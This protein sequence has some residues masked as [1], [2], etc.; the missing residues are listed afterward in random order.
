MNAA[1][2]SVGTTAAGPGQL[3]HLSV[4]LRNS[5][6]QISGLQFDVTY[7]QSA[8]T[9][10][11]A[12]GSA[13]IAAG[14]QVT[15]GEL[16]AGKRILIVGFNQTAI[17]DGSV[18]DFTISVGAS[19]SGSYALAISN[20]SAT[21]PSGNSVPLT[22]TSGAV[23]IGGAPIL[24]IRKSHSGNLSAGQSGALYTVVVSNQAGAGTTSGLV[25]VAETVPAGLTLVSMAGAGWICGGVTC[26]RT[27]SL[28]AAG[29]WPPITVTVNVA[30]NSPP[31]FTN[32]VAV[33]G[34][35]SASAFASDPAT[36]APASQTIVFGGLGDLTFGTPPFVV[37]ATASSGLPV[38]FSSTTTPVCTV[39]GSTVTIVAAGTCAITASQAGNANYLAAPAVTQTFTVKGRPQTIS[40][41]ALSNVAFGTAPFAVVATATSGLAVTFAS[42]TPLVCTIAGVPNAPTRVT[43][44]GSGACSITASQAG[45]SIWAAANAVTQTF[46]VTAPSACTYALKSPGASIALDGGSGTIDLVTGPACRWTAVSNAP[47]ITITAGASGTDSGSIAWSAAAN[48]TRSARTGTITVGGQTYTITQ[49][50]LGITP[51]GIGPLYSTSTTI[52]P[53]SWFSIYGT[54]LANA[55]AQWNGDF[56]TSLGGVSVTVGGKPAYLWYVSSGQ[57]NL[58]APDL[59]ANDAPAGAAIVVVTNG[60]ESVTSTVTIAQ[61]SPA[62]SVLGD[63]KHLAGVILTPDGSG[64]SADGLYDLAGPAGVFAFKTRPVRAG[65]TL[66]LFGVGF[67]PTDPAVAAGHLFSGAAPTINPVA[68]AIGG[69]SAEVSFAGLSAAGLYQ[70]N[71]TVPN[72]ASGD[73][74]VQATADGASTQPG[75]VVA[76]E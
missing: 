7:D 51:G 5:G 52:A 29:S 14:K 3:V 17:L 67:G 23:L 72:V 15:V 41:N 60:S 68:I 55:T 63:G 49:V 20:A 35:G 16:A 76:V 32:Q 8:L 53:G 65:E 25:T 22:A 70:F 2:I 57:I 40:F 62:F 4:P 33:S 66:E 50:S 37:S 1:D 19:A 64:S 61:T 21:D 34:G 28:S 48:G 36:I 10:S 6:T 27:D 26:S 42:T 38:A 9:L 45:N 43:L 59:T 75:L 69:V 30:T 47:W 11:V 73:Q 24:T 46:I 58:Q 31:Q 54:N 18:A 39:S 74:P 13:A 71:L 44:A 56:P 12:T